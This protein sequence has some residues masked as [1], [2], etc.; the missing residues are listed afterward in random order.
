MQGADAPGEADSN[1]L[2]CGRQGEEVSRQDMQN[3]N[4][5]ENDF[6][7]KDLPLLYVFRDAVRSIIYILYL[8]GKSFFFYT[9]H[10]PWGQHFL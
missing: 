4:S 6:D 9:V 1:I 3:Q 10:S 7:K 8:E 5:R 2:M